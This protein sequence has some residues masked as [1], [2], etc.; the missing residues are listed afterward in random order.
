MN[1]FEIRS[2]LH[3]LV[4]LILLLILLIVIAVYNVNKGKEHYM[5]YPEQVN[6][7]GSIQAN[8]E[9]AQANNNYASILLYL[10]KNPARSVK[11]IEDI[12]NKFF[13]TNCNVKHDINFTEIAKMPDGMV[14]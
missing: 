14:F 3:R 11:F 4:F 12:K 9:A 7:F 2:R 1:L 8:P 13:D 10:Q 5:N 6:P